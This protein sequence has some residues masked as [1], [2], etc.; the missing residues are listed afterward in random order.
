MSRIHWEWRRGALCNDSGVPLVR[1]LN[2]VPSERELMAA[3]PEM[4]ALLR[5]FHDEVLSYDGSSAPNG[6]ESAE[7]VRALLKRLEGA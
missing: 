4:L 1:D 6:Y 5:E 2:L 7:R 3:A